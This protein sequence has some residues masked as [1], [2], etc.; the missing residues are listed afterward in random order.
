MKKI[1]IKHSKKTKE[2]TRKPK[3]VSGKVNETALRTA[4]MTEAALC[5]L[6]SVSAVVIAM[7]Y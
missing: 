4:W 2:K 3:A 7:V 1:T 5:L 6:V